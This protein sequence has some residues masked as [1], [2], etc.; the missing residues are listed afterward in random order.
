VIWSTLLLIY[1][2]G[3][4][5]ALAWSLWAGDDDDDL[6]QQCLEAMRAGGLCRQIFGIV[7][8]IVAFLVFGP[9]IPLVSLNCLRD[10]YRRRKYLLSFLRKHT[11]IIL[12]PI[13]ESQIDPSGQEMISQLGP[14]VEALQFEVVNHYLYKTEPFLI[15]N[16]VHLSSDRRTILEVGHIDGEPYLSFSSVLAS[17]AF[18]ESSLASCEFDIQPFIET[19]QVFGRIFGRDSGQHSVRDIFAAH[20][21]LLTE[22]SETNADDAMEIDP[23]RIRD[24]LRYVHRKFSE[25]KFQLDRIDEPPPPPVWP[26]ESTP[27][28]QQ[29]NEQQALG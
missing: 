26:F 18:V 14:D 4:Y 13:A 28:E 8:L 22:L 20:E 24:V 10:N 5:L 1:A 15:E 12:D 27:Q 6:W 23:T 3:C 25:V 7:M 19:G 11:E 29:T 9:F 2:I 16:R 21:R 17:G